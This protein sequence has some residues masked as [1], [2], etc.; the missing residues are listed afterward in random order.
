MENVF[1]CKVFEECFM[2]LRKIF[3]LMLSL[4][5]FCFIH[6]NAAQKV[7]ALTFDDGPSAKYTLQVL[8]ILK[9]NNVK[10]TFFVTGVDVNSF[11]KILKATF[12]DGHEIGNHSFTHPNF[13][14][15]SA[16][17]MKSELTKTNASVYKITQVYPTIFRPPYGA[18]PAACRAVL[19]QVG[20]REIT[21][22]YL[23]N[24]YDYQKTTAEKIASQLI[25]HAHS[26]AI[27]AMHDGGGNRE[28]TVQA[29]PVVISALKKQGYKF[30]TVSELRG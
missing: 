23:V 2:K 22:D 29:L 3:G 28:K 12:A 5:F 20:L 6:A 8:N 15:L 10:A 24:D 1:L 21:W 14:K 16:A 19:K 17:A 13:A 27:L 18:C 26:G 25:A 7:I 11:P 4:P 9:K 30:V